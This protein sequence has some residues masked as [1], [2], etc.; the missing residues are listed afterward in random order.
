[1]KLLRFILGV[2]SILMLGGGFLASLSMAWAGR[3]SEY[4]AKIDQPN[5]VM[6]S[7]GLLLGAVVLCFVKDTEEEAPE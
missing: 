4:A 3:A 5:I 7:L 6:L 2:V 1:M